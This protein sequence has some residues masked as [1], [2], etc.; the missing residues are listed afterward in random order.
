MNVKS[1]VG[2]SFA[3]CHR[4]AVCRIFVDLVSRLPL[5][6]TDVPNVLPLM[7]RNIVRFVNGARY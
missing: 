4:G 3:G 5:R 1:L 2:W 6:P 7:S